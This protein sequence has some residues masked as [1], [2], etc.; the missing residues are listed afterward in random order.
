MREDEDEDAWKNNEDEDED[1]WK[2]NYLNMTPFHCNYNPV[3]WRGTR[4]YCLAN[5]QAE[6]KHL[7]H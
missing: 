7:E 2:N 4:T 3:R 5:M 1:A 6:K